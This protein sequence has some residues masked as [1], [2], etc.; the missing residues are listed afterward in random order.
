MAGLIFISFFLILAE[1][2]LSSGCNYN[3]TVSD[4]PYTITQSGKVYCLNAS[5]STAGTD[6]VLFSEG[7]QNSTLNCQGHSMDG[8]D[9]EDTYGIYISG[10]GTDG[11]TLKNC[12]ISDYFRGVYLQDDRSNTIRN[13]TFVSNARGVTMLNSTNDSLV[14]ANGYNNSVKLLQV[15]DSANVTIVNASSDYAYQGI[16]V[17]NSVGLRLENIYVSNNWFDGV[18]F[19][20]SNSSVF[21]NVSSVDNGQTGFQ[22][23]DSNS[24][25]VEVCK[26]S[27]VLHPHNGSR[28]LSSGTIAGANA[29]INRT[30]DLSGVGSATLTFWHWYLSELD[31]DGGR[32]E[33]Y[34]ATSLQ[35]QILY[36]ASGE[37]PRSEGGLSNV[38]ALGSQGYMGQAGLWGNATFNLTPFVGGT[39]KIRFKYASDI[40]G[41]WGPGWF[42]DDIRVPQ[43]GYFEGAED[44]AG[45]DAWTI[46][47]FTAVG[48]V[49]TQDFGF[50][51]FQSDNNT[52]SGCTVEGNDQGVNM[53]M[54]GYSSPNIFFNN[55]FNN[56]DNFCFET[57]GDIYPNSWNVSEQAGERI[58]S[59]GTEI[60]GN[61]WT[62]PSGDGYSD[63]C[64][65]ADN[66]GMCDSAYPID[67]LAT[68]NNTDYSALSDEFN[69]VWLSLISPV[70]NGGFVSGGGA[71]SYNVSDIYNVSNCTLMLNGL[72][73]QTN[74]TVTLSLS[75]SF[76]LV[77]LPVG[78]YNWSVTCTD[79]QGF[80]RTTNARSFSVFTSS[81]FAGNTTDLTGVDTSNITGLVIDSPSFGTIQFE[82]PVDL[83]GGADLDSVV[84]I[85]YGRIEINSTA[86]PGLNVSATLSFYNLT[87]S[88]P[89]IMKDGTECT[90]CEEVSYSNGT[91]VFNVTSFSVYTV[92]ETPTTTTTIPAT[93][94]VYSSPSGSLYQKTLPPKEGHVND[95]ALEPTGGITDS[96]NP[97]QICDMGCPP[98]SDWSA[99]AGGVSKRSVYR[100]NH[101]GSI[102]C[103]EQV[104]TIECISQID[105]PIMV[106]QPSISSDPAVLLIIF[107]L[108]VSIVLI[109]DVWA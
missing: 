51:M 21:V 13:I 30:F 28:M 29:T 67:P 72:E 34:N 53:T 82:S 92:Q 3:I 12:I 85:S 106:Y 20:N 8:D 91:Y 103:E 58:Y 78:I 9:S 47:G 102:A 38:S 22:F 76:S 96:S 99:C 95:S 44:Q 32:V 25:T 7:V 14:G 86:M 70:D 90:D 104:E 19:E 66:D 33:F 15:E 43:I 105:S 71:L 69:P 4:L 36:P 62:S 84:N 55:I 87:L 17:F 73:N 68:G 93:T 79:E 5:V 2:A 45:L 77:T 16:V 56:T 1:P 24:N 59:R 27:S 89:M 107:A 6:A 10:T 97:T 57:S 94:T 74:E 108:V 60:A 100:C 11:N 98:P 109:P 50:L 35:W 65:D 37:Y 61:Y 48:D 75:Q 42:V 81:E 54:A 46:D 26:A 64:V 80:I 88:E 83:S 23:F 52:V 40:A 49:P 31:A 18:Y 39:V 101:A 41:A 63:T